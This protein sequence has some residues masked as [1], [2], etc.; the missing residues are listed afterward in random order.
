MKSASLDHWRDYFRS[1][2]SDIFDI[3]DHA[4]MVA[5]ADCP[6]EL[7]LRRDRI[8][9]KLFC[10]RFN[11]CSDQ[12]ESPITGRP[13]SAI[14]DD[15]GDGE[16]DDR[17]FQR[18]FGA[19]GRKESKVNSTSRDDQDNEEM[20]N[21]TPMVSNY[22]SEDADALTDEIEEAHQTVEEVL[23]IKDILH[24]SEDES[25]TVL[26]DSLRRLQ[27]MALSV[28]ILKATEIGKA[29]NGLRKHGSSQIRHLARTLIELWKELVDEWVNATKAVAGGEEGTPDSVNPSVLDEEEGLPSPP[30]DDGVFFAT[31]PTSMELSQFFDGMD[32]DGNPRNSGE[33]IKNRAS[34][35]RPSPKNQN[36]IKRKQQTQNEGNG[37]T[38]ENKSKSHLIKRQEAVLETRKPSNVASGPGRPQK[39]GKEQKVVSESKLL[40]RS[41]KVTIQ[42]K[43]LSAPQDKF[44]CSDEVTVQRK[45]E[46]TKRKLQESY[47]HAE[48]AKKKRTIQVMEL[49]DIPKQGLGHKNQPMRAGNHNRNRAQGRR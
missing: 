43:P 35:R 41:D 26:Y 6:E 2:D 28:D 15:G 38:K 46:A 48:N 42:K 19:G 39:V 14:S 30:L 18:E 45:L 47:Q 12:V 37:F 23:R 40:Q 29:V 25:D 16:H 5:A 7:R 49:H 3:I 32:D 34:G 22:S 4:V 44:K 13:G 8:A 31:Q 33:F 11:R 36:I 9:E 21:G 27:L 10:C 20:Q 17:G 1:A 24:D